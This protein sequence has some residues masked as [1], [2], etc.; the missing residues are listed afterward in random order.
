MIFDIDGVICDS[1][2][3]FKRL[4]MRA[5][6]RKQRNAFV[7][8]VNAYNADCKGDKPLKFGMELLTALENYYKP[9]K[10]F[11]ITARGIGG[12]I[13][14]LNW[15]KRQSFWIYMGVK[16]ELIM[17]E[18][19]LDNFEF[20]SQFEHANYKKRTAKALMEKYDIIIAVDDSE[21]NCNAYNTLNIPVLK[22]TAPNLGRVLV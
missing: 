11:F 1:S 16:C 17:N 3:R 14:T 10:I 12:Y 4:N 2:T 7:K 21:D 22:F 13:P 8:S 15:L 19:D 18:E 5:Y 9:D 6:N 20:S